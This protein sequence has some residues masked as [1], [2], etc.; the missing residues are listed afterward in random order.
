MGQLNI[1]TI[2]FVRKRVIKHC[3]NLH[4]STQLQL[5]KSRAVEYNLN[6][7]TLICNSRKVKRQNIEHLAFAKVFT[8][9]DKLRNFKS[10]KTYIGKVKL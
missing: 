9:S 1:F 2:S 3:V 6:Q 8:V 10:V 7:L 4:N 5:A